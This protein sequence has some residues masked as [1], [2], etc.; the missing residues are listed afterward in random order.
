MK[1]IYFAVI[2]WTFVSVIIIDVSGCGVDR[3]EDKVCSEGDCVCEVSGNCDFKCTKGNCRIS[4]KEN[5]VCNSSCDGGGCSQQCDPGA[6]CTFN[7]DGGNCTQQCG[8][9]SECSMSCS[10]GE[11]KIDSISNTA[12]SLGDL[13][14]L[15]NY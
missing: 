2:L 5:S 11:C 3:D 12:N 7:C 10:G 13:N 14:N 6:N 8:T 15:T 1:K 4:C 9:N